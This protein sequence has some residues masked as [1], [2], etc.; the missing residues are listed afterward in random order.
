V[1]KKRLGRPALVAALAISAG[2]A[3][4]TPLTSRPAGAS[5]SLVVRNVRVFDAPHA[6]LLDGVRDVVVRDGKIAAIEP[7][8]RGPT[9]GPSLDGAGGTLLPGLIDAHAH[10]GGSSNPAWKT[11]FP[12]AT[13]NLAAFVYA[14]VTT[15]LDLGG[16]SPAIFDERAKIASGARLGPHL[17][18][19]GPMFTAPGGHPVEVFQEALPWYLRWYV[20]PRAARQIATPAQAKEAVDGLLPERPDILKLAVDA[21]PGGNVP[22]L[23]P[24]TIAALAAAGHGARLRSIA[25]VGTSAEA[26]DAVNGGVDALAHAPFY[27]ALSDEAVAAIAAKHVPVVVTLAIWDGLETASR[28]NDFLPIEREVAGPALIAELSAPPPKPE[29]PSQVAFHRAVLAAHA[30]R[31]QNV[32]KLRA[33]GVTILAGSDACN[34]GDLPGAGL[35]VE[36]EK[37]V[38]AGLTPGEALRAATYDNARFIAGDQAEFG[39]IEVGKRA[40]LVLVSGD[41]VGRIADLGKIAQVILD[42]AVLTRH[43]HP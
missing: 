29:P 17:Y 1:Q 41:P 28:A 38:E 32:A 30:A 36:L 22:R 42:G 40:D 26:L 35:H 33:A 25:H 21:G 15:A 27:Q 8:G 11:S 5:R 39:A 3:R 7:A 4:E 37:L 18:A 20:I 9:D 24:A 6:A 43:A 14:G 13:A 19:A 23:D 12:D 34:A 10:T 2:C 16:L 31:R